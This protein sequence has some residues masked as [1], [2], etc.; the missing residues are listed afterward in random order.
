MAAPSTGV[1]AVDTL[2]VWGGVVSLVV[3][4][5]ALA[6]RGIR[7]GVR[8]GRR[9]DEFIDD[10]RGEPSRPGVPARPGVM[11]RM[12]GLET[13]MNGF[14]DDLQRIKHELYPNG[15]GSLRDAVNLANQQ[16]AHLCSGPTGTP[17][18]EPDRTG[19][20]LSPLGDPAGDTPSSAGDRGGP[21]LGL[22]SGDTGGQ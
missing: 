9:M 10:W 21:P 14:D 4:L 8:I 22:T 20:G 3:T 11:E 16:L 6:W 12:E 13:R 15:G 7:S 19:D 5:G 2:L 18:P 17:V 1:P